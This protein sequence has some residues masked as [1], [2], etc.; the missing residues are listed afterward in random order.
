M[1]AQH[2]AIECEQFYTAISCSA[3]FF[4]PANRNKSCLQ[5]MSK[6][7]QASIMRK[8]KVKNNTDLM[9]YAMNHGII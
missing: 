8:P 1:G 5:D 4:S 7:H 6:R 2:F 3:G 9:K